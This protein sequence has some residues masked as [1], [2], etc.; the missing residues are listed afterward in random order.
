MQ[1]ALFQA[2]QPSSLLLGLAGFKVTALLD[3]AMNWYTISS[4]GSDSIK[5]WKSTYLLAQMRLLM[6]SGT[7]FAS[8][9]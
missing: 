3:E 4:V 6:L 8:M 7:C 1:K 2:A 5:Y 9:K